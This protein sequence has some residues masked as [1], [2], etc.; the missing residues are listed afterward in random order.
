MAYLRPKEGTEGR[1]AFGVVSPVDGSALP[2]FDVTNADDVAAAITR[3]RAAQRHWGNTPVADRAALA[4]RLLSVLLERKDEVIARLTAETGRPEMDTLLIEL[5]ASCDVI[6]YYSRRAEKILADRRLGLHLLRMKR[7]KIVYKPLGVVAVISPWNGPFILSMNP[8]IQAVLAGNAVLLK[9]SEVTPDAGRLVQELFDAAGFPPNVV[10]TLLGDGETGAA[11]INGGVD[12]VTFTGSV[13]TGR[14]IGEAC[15][16]NLVPCT[17][18]LGG[19]DPMI[20]LEDADMVRAAGGAVFGGMMNTGQFCMGV[21]RIYVLRSVAEEFTAK[22]VAKVAEMEYGRD[23]GPFISEQQIAIVERHVDAAVAGGARVAIGGRRDGNTY[24]PT[25]ITDVDHTMA[26]MT[27]E[28]FGPVLPI[29]PVDS[30]DE[31][32]RLANDSEYGLCASVWTSD[33]ERGERIGRLLES[34]SVMINETSMVYGA[35]ELPF[36]GVKASGVGQ[37]NGLD[38]L[39]NY[40]H[41]FSI[42]SD[43]FLMKEESVWFPY[44]PDKT[45]GIKRALGVIWGSPLKRFM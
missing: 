21:E 18:E 41:A 29:V 45:A 16:R 42:I 32:V 13:A 6:N 27:E 22:V 20:V 14:K 25:V 23:F 26:L 2:P 40:S 5:F 15:G 37:T 1:R 24:L 34:G 44:L 33:P 17:L 9:P 38:S 39:R 7:G 12:K 30:V 3:A 8:T 4:Q 31:A 10:Q 36:G 19:K 43:R 28:T 11:L 35:L